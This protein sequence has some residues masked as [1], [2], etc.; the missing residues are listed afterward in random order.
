MIQRKHV[1]ASLRAVE[2]RH[3]LQREHR[4][5]TYVCPVQAALM[6]SPMFL[7][8]TVI[9]VILNVI[10]PVGRNDDPNCTIATEMLGLCEQGWFLMVVL[11]AFCCYTATYLIIRGVREHQVVKRHIDDVIRC[12][13]GLCADGAEEASFHRCAGV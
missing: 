9:G 8:G 4:P 13:F 2:I 7:F 10:L 1:D 11:A 5:T 12:A 6:L 3:R